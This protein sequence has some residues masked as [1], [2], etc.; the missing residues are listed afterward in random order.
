MRNS[1][2]SAF[3]CSHCPLAGFRLPDLIA[4]STMELNWTSDMAMR[5][6]NGARTCSAV[7]SGLV[8]RP[9]PR[10]ESGTFRFEEIEKPFFT[11]GFHEMPR[12]TK[13]VSSLTGNNRKGVSPGKSVQFLEVRLRVELLEQTL[14]GLFRASGGSLEARRRCGKG[15][16]P[17]F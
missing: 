3:R 1:S 13:R 12:S 8:C 2:V 17:E 10:S 4:A 7:P 6:G 9:Q 5:R 16:L 14:D 15:S 11:D